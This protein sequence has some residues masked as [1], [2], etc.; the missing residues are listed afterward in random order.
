[1]PALL[2][3]LSDLEVIVGPGTE[4]AWATRALRH[5]SDEIRAF[6]RN[7]FEHL[8][9]SLVLNGSGS[10]ILLVPFTPVIAVTG[11]REAQWTSSPTDLDGPDDGDSPA[12]EW[13]E[14]GIL[15]RIDGGVWVRRRR[16]YLVTIEAGYELVPDIVSTIALQ[17]ASRTYEA[18][19]DG[20]SQETLGGYSY[21]RQASYSSEGSQAAYHL[22][23]EERDLLADYVLHG[24]KPKPNAATSTSGS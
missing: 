4:E 15:E 23:R 3:E 11:V 5:A 18:G 8:E 21:A 6:T 19:P 7:P 17:L 12:W 16:W 9:E 14:D 10:R 24:V 1:M 13:D 22:S 20:L 2:A